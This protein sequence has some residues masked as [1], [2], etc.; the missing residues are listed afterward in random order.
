MTARLLQKTVCAIVVAAAVIAVTSPTMH[1][2]STL[3]GVTLDV[4]PDN[5][6]NAL[7]DPVPLTMH[8]VN[9]SPRVIAMPADVSV[10][11]GH[12]EVWI[13][14]GDG[15]FQKYM[16]PGWGLRDLHG[17]NKTLERGRPWTA[18][19]TI[20]FNHGVA[21]DHLNPAA[22]A[23][24]LGDRMPKSGFAFAA[25]GTYQ[26]KVRMYS[27]DFREYIESA[28]IG[29]SMREPE[30]IDGQV[31]R[32]LNQDPELAYFMHAQGPNGHPASATSEALVATIERLVDAYPSSRYAEGMKK[33]VAVYS[34]RMQQTR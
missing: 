32:A 29:L 33:S 16:G 25:A 27:I 18:T 8:I 7:G 4:R 13:A 15:P 3:D 26:M 21:T 1:A 34:A 24:A 5:Q 11:S 20:L 9:T 6:V 19:A 2:Q 12:L 10:G 17:A 31:W 23:A 14:R 28:P 22:A 30:G